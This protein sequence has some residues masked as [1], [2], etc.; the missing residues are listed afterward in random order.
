MWIKYGNAMYNTDGMV[1]IKPVR[2][3]IKIKFLDGSYLAL[4]HFR[5][6]EETKEYYQRIVTNLLTEDPDKPGMIIKDTKEV[7]K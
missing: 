6:I 4:G 7:K 1:E 5:T 3:T 2:T